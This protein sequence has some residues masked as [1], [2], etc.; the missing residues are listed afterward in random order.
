VADGTMGP[1][2]GPA[3]RVL[4]RKGLLAGVGVAVA[5]VALP[6]FA[7]IAQASTVE[8]DAFGPLGLDIT[9]SAQ[10]QWWWCRNCTGLFYSASGAATG[11]C[12]FNG[13]HDPTGSWMY[14]T[15][16]VTSQDVG[17]EQEQ[18]QHGWLWCNWCTGLFW[19]SGVNSS[20]C[21]GNLISFAPNITGPHNA[22]DGSYNYLLPYNGSEGDW[23][24]ATPPMQGG[25]HWCQRCQGLFHPSSGTSGG[26]CPALQTEGPHD[27]G[28]T[29]Y[30]LFVGKS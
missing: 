17:A 13:H 4:L 8:A 29:N 7:G 6:G 27:G 5:S 28:G 2:R 12:P 23:S 19:G 24:L 20:H 10:N 26:L 30:Q 22:S 18:A 14:E 25:W 21:P 15:P 1:G 16:F 9:F 11:A 3:R